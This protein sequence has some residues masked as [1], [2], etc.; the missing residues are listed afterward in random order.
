MVDLLYQHADTKNGNRSGR[1]NFPEGSLMILP[2]LER[3][4]L[5]LCIDN[6]TLE[7]FLNA[8]VGSC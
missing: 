6:R 7:A 2:S 5:I 1:S 8:S 3:R 4:R